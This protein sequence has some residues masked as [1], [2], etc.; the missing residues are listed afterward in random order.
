MNTTNSELKTATVAGGCFWG[1]EEYYRRLKGIVDTQVGFAHEDATFVGTD[2]IDNLIEA[3]MLTYDPSVITFD[4]IM[5]HLFRIVD[6]TS[7]DRQGPDQGLHYR[8]GIFYDQLS[9]KSIIENFI[10]SKASQYSERIQV[11]VRN[12][13]HFQIAEARHQAYLA[14]NPS[15]QCHV[16]FNLIQDDEKK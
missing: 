2:N 12:L 3:V 15:A 6:P 10:A 11:Q 16:D 9:D 1:V 13:H 5:D 14:N 7:Y 4:K 8:T